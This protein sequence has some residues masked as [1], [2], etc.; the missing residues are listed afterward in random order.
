MHIPSSTLAM[1]TAYVLLLSGES[2]CAYT[3]FADAKTPMFTDIR[4]E[5]RID[6]SKVGASMGLA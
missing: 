5:P 3:M 2:D 4:L 6:L 1:E